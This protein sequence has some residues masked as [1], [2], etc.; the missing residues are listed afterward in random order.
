MLLHIFSIF[1]IVIVSWTVDFAFEVHMRNCFLTKSHEWEV[2]ELLWGVCVCVG[3]GGGYVQKGARMCSLCQKLLR[4]VFT[5]AVYV[6]LKTGPSP[7]FTEF[8]CAFTFGES[9]GHFSVELWMIESLL[10]CRPRQD[11]FSQWRRTV[12]EEIFVWN[13]IL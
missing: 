4:A 1:C 13:L 8:P 6:A 7:N 5:L 11:S 2:Y 12:K 9:T 10:S 3:G